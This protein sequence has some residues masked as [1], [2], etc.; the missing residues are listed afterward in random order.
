M[1][2]KKREQAKEW[3]IVLQKQD[4]S[5]DM[6]I[7][8]DY[9]IAKLDNL[10]IPYYATILHNR[11]SIVEENEKEHYHIVIAFEK[12]F[13]KSSV[14]TML[15]EGLGVNSDI[16]SID[17]CSSIKS[18]VRY[19]IH[20]DQVEKYQFDESEIITNNIDKTSEFLNDYVE[21]TTTLINKWLASGANRGELFALIGLKNY[22]AIN[23]VVNSLTSTYALEHKVR[24]LEAMNDSLKREVERLRALCVENNVC[25]DILPFDLKMF[26]NS[27]K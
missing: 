26:E 6:T 11:F 15:A 22:Q 21:P 13:D 19:L 2:N 20:K 14:L 24:H 16:I 18:Q 12:V 10:S 23:G 8:F 5:Q 1:E 7:E 17:K 9:L 4:Y 3:C 25:P 27:E